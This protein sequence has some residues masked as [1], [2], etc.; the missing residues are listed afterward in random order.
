MAYKLKIL[1]AIIPLLT[2]WVFSQTKMEHTRGAAR[3]ERYDMITLFFYLERVCL[4]RLGLGLGSQL[5][6]Q[7]YRKKARSYYPIGTIN[8]LQSHAEFPLIACILSS[9]LL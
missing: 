9:E 7:H 5:P 1:I 4:I 2:H 6:L 8:L 3:M